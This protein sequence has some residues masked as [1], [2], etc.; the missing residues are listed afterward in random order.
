MPTKRA[1]VRSSKKVVVQQAKKSK[2]IGK[3]V[4][5]NAFALHEA[6]NND[7]IAMVKKLLEEGPNVDAKDSQGCTPL[8]NAVL[9]GKDLIIIRELL[10]YGADPMAESKITDGTILH[11]ACGYMGGK[12]QVE[13][14]EELLKHGAEINAKVT[15]GQ[16]PLFEASI[17]GKATGDGDAIDEETAES[18][19]VVKLLLKNGAN[20]NAVT[21]GQGMT[22]LFCT[23]QRGILPVVQELLKNGANPNIA[24]QH[25]YTS[26]HR[27]CRKLDVAMPGIKEGPYSSGITDILATLVDHGA[28][29]NAQD[30][31]GKTPMHHFINDESLLKKYLEKGGKN[32]DFNIKDKIGLT[33][34]D[35]TMEKGKILFPEAAKMIASNMAKGA[36]KR[37]QTKSESRKDSEHQIF[38]QIENLKRAQEKGNFDPL[39]L[40]Q[41][42]GMQ[43]CHQ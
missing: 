35:S 36:L 33:A 15:N 32:I 28:D 18:L 11:V 22:A 38:D 9:K 34:L 24:D 26:L 6:V 20:V 3:T 7:Q 31:K 10:K 13:V 37:A 14:V 30:G 1:T 43:F 8:F 27:V 2:V 4:E 5:P 17:R 19:K 16:T 12:V 42:F 25:G 40:L 29:V 21:N 39:M 41:L 23:V